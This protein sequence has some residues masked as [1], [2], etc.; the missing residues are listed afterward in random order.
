MRLIGRDQLL[1]VFRDMVGY[2]LDA[3]NVLIAVQ[4]TEI[5]PL[6]EIRKYDQAFTLHNAKLPE[7]RGHN[8][9][10]HALLNG[11]T[12]YTS[13]IAWM[14]EKVDTGD[15]A[16]QCTI[17]IFE[18][19]TAFSLYQRTMASCKLILS[20]LYVDL[21]TGTPIPR[22]PQVGTPHYYGKELDKQIKRWEDI[23]RVARAFSF[24]SHA[25]AY[26]EMDGKRY[27]VWTA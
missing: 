24:P 1:S 5:I 8:T 17:P 26:I 13:T 4:A 14:A 10:S 18:H 3:N 11:E 25:P 6:D 23:P 15:I 27:N 22:I 2:S 12:E 9:I 7:Y 21:M 20:Q 16:Y 19:D